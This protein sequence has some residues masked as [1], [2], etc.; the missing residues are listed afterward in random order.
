MDLFFPGILTMFV[1]FAV[2]MNARSI[3][4]ERKKGTLERLLT[5]NLTVGQLFIGKF[6][7]NCSRGFVQTLIL[8]VLA[9]AVFQ[10]ATPISFFECVAFAIVYVAAVSSLGL[11]IAS[12]VRTEDQATWLSVFFTMTM[13]VIS[14]TFFE[15]SEGS[16]MDTLSKISVNTYA[17]DAFRTIIAEEGG[18][19][20]LGLELGIM[21]GVAMVGLIVSRILFRVVSEGK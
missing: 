10:L 20:D 1:L 2:T 17:N 9:F 4:E 19:A 11:I 13:V 5:T 6:F 7:A 8:L 14:G 21:A 12:I 3:V 18:L 15:I 16:L